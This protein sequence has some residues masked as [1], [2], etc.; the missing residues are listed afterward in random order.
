MCLIFQENSFVNWPAR[1]HEALEIDSERRRGFL[2]H[3]GFTFYTSVDVSGKGKTMVFY[4]QDNETSA[5]LNPTEQRYH[6]NKQEF[7]AAIW[8]IKR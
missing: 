6:I 3:A 7:L 4:Q 1:Y 8:A 2:G 5:K